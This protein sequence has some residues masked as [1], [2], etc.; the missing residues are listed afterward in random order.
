M[1]GTRAAQWPDGLP[2]FVERLDEMLPISFWSEPLDTL[3]LGIEF[4]EGA[5]EFVEAQIQR[6][7]DRASTADQDTLA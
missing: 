3:A 1:P 5:S 2:E 4:Q 6:L 7:K